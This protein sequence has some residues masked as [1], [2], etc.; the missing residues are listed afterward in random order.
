MHCDL[1]HCFALS[2][3]PPPAS[4]LL[5]SQKYTQNYRAFKIRKF[6]RKQEGI[7][8]KEQSKFFYSSKCKINR[9]GIRRICCCLD[10]FWEKAY[11]IAEKKLEKDT[12]IPNT[13]KKATKT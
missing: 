3:S 4:S 9:L 11:K 12:G 6:I 8:Q 5:F 2:L 10:K 1:W 7:D 13:Y